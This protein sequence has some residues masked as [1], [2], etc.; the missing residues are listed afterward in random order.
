VIEAVLRLRRMAISSRSR[1]LPA[2]KIPPSARCRAPTTATSARGGALVRR[3]KLIHTF[4]ATSP[5]H[6]EKK[7]RMTPDQ[8]FEQAK[9]ACASP[10]VYRRYRFSRKRSRSDMDSCAAIEADRRSATTI[11]FADTRLWRAGVYGT[12]LRTLRER[13]PN[14]DKGDWSCTAITTSAWRSQF[15]GGGV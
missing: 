7:L 2:D 8:V 6:M 14:S 13:I 3:G 12:M 15:V 9:Q 4:I 10:Q 5:L 1:R 11:N